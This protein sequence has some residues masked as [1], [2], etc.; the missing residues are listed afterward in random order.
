M[1]V[2]PDVKLFVFCAFKQMSQNIAFTLLSYLSQVFP[3]F[4]ESLKFLAGEFV[5]LHLL[6]V[7]VRQL[8]T[9]SLSQERL[10]VI[11]T[12]LTYSTSHN[13]VYFQEIAQPL[14]IN[15]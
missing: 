15:F 11:L 5:I 3:D 6:D 13:S 14:S 2:H 1:I 9:S 12:K 10:S 4:H 8:S 7:G